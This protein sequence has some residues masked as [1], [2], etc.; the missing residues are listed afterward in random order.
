MQ[1]QVEIIID[2]GMPGAVSADVL[3]QRPDAKIDD[4]F[5]LTLHYS[6]QRVCLR[7][8]TLIAEPR[9]RF[10]VHGTAGSFVKYGLDP[11]EAQLKSGMN[12]RDAGFGIDAHDG[13]LT[14]PDGTHETVPSERG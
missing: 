6:A 5:D 11:Q 8:S 9:P 3:A 2:L 12:A 13:R 10:A 4:Y 1:R 7:C 14:L